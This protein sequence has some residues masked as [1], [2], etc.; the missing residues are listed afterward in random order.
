MHKKSGKAYDHSSNKCS[1]SFAAICTYGKRKHVHVVVVRVGMHQTLHIVF[2]ESILRAAK[3]S[4]S[5]QNGMR[6]GAQ[7]TTDCSKVKCYMWTLIKRDIFAVYDDVL[8]L[9]LLHVR[10]ESSSTSSVFERCARNSFRSQSFKIAYFPHKKCT[11]NAGI[12][13]PNSMCDV[14][15]VCFFFLFFWWLACDDVSLVHSTATSHTCPRMM[16][17][18]R[19]VDVRTQLGV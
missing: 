17:T 2:F 14:L 3:R 12:M 8:L 4:S 19:Y 7:V 18:E 9:L 15:C 5:Y 10:V 6:M 16:I 11:Q 13:A 1:C